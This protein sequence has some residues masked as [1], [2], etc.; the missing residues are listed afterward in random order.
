YKNIGMSQPKLTLEQ[1]FKLRSLIDEVR[2]MSEKDAK[3]NLIDL[4]KLGMLKDNTFKQ[5]MKGEIETWKN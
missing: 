4:I 1:E 5:V 2:L 3:K